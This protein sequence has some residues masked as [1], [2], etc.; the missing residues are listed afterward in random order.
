MESFKGVVLPTVAGGVLLARDHGLRVEE[1]AI[2]AVPDLV[3]HAGLKID[4]EG[5]RHMLPR[6][7]LGE[8]S[9]EAI[10]SL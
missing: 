9:A 2:G 1:A 6:G 10:V 3:N 4:V 8:E 5:A 7:S